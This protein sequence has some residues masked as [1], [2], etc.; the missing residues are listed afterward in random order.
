MAQ[1]TGVRPISV[2]R[3]HKGA[4]ADPNQNIVSE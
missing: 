1:N 2:L 3:P 4:A